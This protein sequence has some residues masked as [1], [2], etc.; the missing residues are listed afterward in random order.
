MS[1]MDL[2]QIDELAD[3]KG[4]K[5]LSSDGE[6]IGK[7]EQIW[8]DN[9]N[10]QPEWAEVKTGLLPGRARYVP[11]RAAEFGDGEVRLAYT[12]REVES[13]PDFDPQTADQDEVVGLYRHFRQPLPT[14]GPP[15]V[16]NPFDRLT[17][18]WVPGVTQKVEEITSRFKS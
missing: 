3:L 17:A 9:V 16:R 12:K 1:D 4:A 7:L 13:A 10:H 6:K 8:V 11:L 5:A 14:P 2:S 18:T 15:K